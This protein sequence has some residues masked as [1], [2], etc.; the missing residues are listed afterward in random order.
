M[1]NMLASQ[2][3]NVFSGLGDSL[4]ESFGDDAVG[5]ADALA[6]N[7]LKS[8]GLDN[9]GDMSDLNDVMSNIKEIFMKMK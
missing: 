4:S 7:G 5:N 8:L 6:E 1:S 9:I 2:L 3:Q